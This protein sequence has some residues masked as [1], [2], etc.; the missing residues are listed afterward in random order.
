MSLIEFKDLC[1]GYEHKVIIKKIN[2]EINDGEYVCVFGDN[3]VG[4]TTFLKTILGLI[5]PVSGSI[6]YEE[7]FNKKEVGYLPQSSQI[8]PEF[9]ASCFEVVLSGCV[10]KLKLWPFY[11]KVHKDLALEKMKLLGVRNLANK[12]FRDLSGG[13][14]QRVLL[15][16]ALCATDR[17][18]VLDEPFTG[19]DYN[20]T[21][22]LYQ[23]LD[24][25]N[26]ELHVTIIGKGR[27]ARTV[28]IM[29]SVVPIIRKYIRSEHGSRPDPDA[30]LFFSQSKGL[31]AKPSERGVNKQLEKYSLM[32]REI[33]PEVPKHIHS[34]QFRH[35]MATHC[36]EDGM[37][38]FQISKM[39]GHKSVGTTMTYLGMTVAMTEDAVKKVESTTARS[40]KP[41]WSSTMKLK[42][43]F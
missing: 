33:C 4:K 17:I 20:S 12:P 24:K 2:L 5:P 26:K 3:G 39:L 1:I 15:A 14:K 11:R 43:L 22:S 19:L 38:V 31:F 36:L 37:N 13:Q 23:L 9:P 27:K 8:K 21:M 35:S 7:G 29:S 40:V 10:N 18:L 30:Y 6:I 16:R 34:H 32:A 42:D 28:Y 41:K 25:I